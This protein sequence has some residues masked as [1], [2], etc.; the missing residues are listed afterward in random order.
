MR[1]RAIILISAVAVL[2]GTAISG[3]VQATVPIAGFKFVEPVRVFDSRALPDDV[4]ADEPITFPE[5]G[6]RHIVS[7]TLSAATEPSWVYFHTCGEEVDR[8]QPAANHADAGLDRVNL[9]PVDNGEC[10]TLIGS[11]GLTVDLIAVQGAA[12]GMAYVAHPEPTYITATPGYPLMDV[13]V[14]GA[15]VP[16]SA[17]AVALEVTITAG[18]GFAG[19][20]LIECGT[21]NHLM[22]AIGA[23]P[24]QSATGLILAP[25]DAE[26]D[27]CFLVGAKP[28]EVT[29]RRLGYLSP[30]ATPTA[31][32]L[33]YSGFVEREMPGFEA[34]P[35]VRLFDTR[36]SGA[37]IPGLGTYRYQVTGLPAGATAVALNITATE[38]SAPGFASAYPC[39]AG[40]VPE[41]SNV[42]WTG[43]AATVPNFSVVSLGET[44]ELCFFALSATHLIADLAGYFI[45]GGGSGFVPLAPDRL[46]DTRN[47]GG[48]IPAGTI[49]EFDLDGRVPAGSTAAVLN[50]TVTEPIAPGF[51]SAFP[52]GQAPP[53]SSNVNYLAGETRPNVATVK[54]P[55]DGRVCFFTSAQTHL[56]ADLAGAFAPTSDVGFV[57]VEPFRYFDTRVD[58]GGVPFLANEELGLTFPSPYLA[59]LAWNLT[60]TATEGAGFV[61]GYPCAGGLPPVSNVNYSGAGQTL[62]NFAFLTPDDAGDLCFYA[63]TGTH[64]IA[65]EAGYF[66]SPVPWE[67]YYDG[68]PQAFGA[69]AD[70]RR[71]EPAGRP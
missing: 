67:V 28:D 43:A 23:A 57:A 30:T 26:G 37:P 51:V 49:H 61:A 31:E 52:C 41:V 17:T 58:F 22:Q 25:I 12:N 6:I 29:V 64:L 47:A 8:S 16:T 7:L 40:T 56:I 4:V 34:V 70:G 59:A 15:G 63:L 9:A 44:G 62:A 5:A 66:V 3:S 11:A 55:A 21:A 50:V 2:T 1:A 35:P 69:T 65:D 39:D 60:V 42:N 48:P 68:A 32:G 18:L 10:M 27:V 54:V 36:D 38:T 45:D 14:R 71:A 46:F 24:D 13:A 19:V 33:P 53:D 20:E